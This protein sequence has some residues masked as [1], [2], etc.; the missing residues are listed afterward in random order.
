MMQLLVIT[1]NL[2]GA[3]FRQRIGAYLDLLHRQ[4]IDS[5]IA[6]LPAGMWGRRTLLASAPG[7]DGILLHRK[8]LGVWDGHCLRRGGR[9][10]IYDFDDAVMYDNRRPAR[11]AHLR[12]Q[13][14]RRSAAHACLVLAGNEYLAE[15]ARR[16]NTQ[17]QVVPT[18]LDV[19]AYRAGM[20]RRDDGLVRLVWIG[21]GSTLK[22]LREIRPALEEVGRRFPNVV[23]RLVCDEF[24]NFGPLP[25]EKRRWSK[26]TEAADL[27]TSDIGLAPLPDDRFARG[28]CGFKILQYQA[29]GLP[30][31]ASPVGVN[32]QYVRDGVTGFL[33]QN[34]AQW[35]DRLRTL[36]EN[37]GLRVNLGQCGQ[38]DVERFDV[39]V[40]GERF[41]RLI[42][43]CLGQGDDS[44]R[45]FFARDHGS[46]SQDRS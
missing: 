23:L 26:D 40:I 18:G 27:S 28:K 12:L 31:V 2:D 38:S 15:H 19:N 45:A 24:V 21:S 10:L 8:L 35:I 1:N 34:G 14:F 29:A 46:A 44:G 9:K 41:C 43:E 6:T 20:Q 25:V 30:V 3:S 7:W 37:P 36:I 39:R 42:A 22:Y 17:V 4:G 32:A 16:Y 33:A 5:R 13:R 11:A